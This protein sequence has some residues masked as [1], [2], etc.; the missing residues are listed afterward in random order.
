MNEFFSGLGPLLH[1]GLLQTYYDDAATDVNG[2]DMRC[3]S[4]LLQRRTGNSSGVNFL[5]KNG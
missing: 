5:D 3:P 4:G 2:L 1:G